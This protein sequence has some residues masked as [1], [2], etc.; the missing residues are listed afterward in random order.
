MILK[1]TDTVVF[2]IPLTVTSLPPYH[3]T[4]C[5]LCHFIYCSLA[6]LLPAPVLLTHCPFINSHSSIYHCWYPHHSSN[7]AALFAIMC[8]L[9]M[10]S[11]D[12]VTDQIPTTSVFGGLMHIPTITLHYTVTDWCLLPLYSSAIQCQTHVLYHY[13][14][15]MLADPC[16]PQTYFPAIQS[17]SETFQYCNPETDQCSPQMYLHVI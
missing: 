9:L 11:C 8:P 17:Q 4:I 5:I 14:W 2:I 6:V 10:D 3:H 13:V 16:S 1:D 7:A 15:S 12:T